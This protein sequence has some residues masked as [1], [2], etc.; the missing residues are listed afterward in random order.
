MKMIVRNRM[1]TA[2]S[3]GQASKIQIS[4]VIE[5]LPRKDGHV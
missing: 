4:F 5:I 3:Y 2:L 1:D